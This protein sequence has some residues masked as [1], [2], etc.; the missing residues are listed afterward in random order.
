MGVQRGSDLHVKILYPNLE[1]GLADQT[2]DALAEIYIV[3]EVAPGDGGSIEV[4]R[5]DGLKCGRC[6]RH[7]PEVDDGGLCARCDEVVNGER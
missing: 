5:T 2:L 6:W 7:L 1:L 4:T 3:S